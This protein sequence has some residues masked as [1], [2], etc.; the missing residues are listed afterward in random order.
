MAGGGHHLAQINIGRLRAPIDSPE[1]AEFV[2]NL[3]RINALAEAQPGFVWRLTGGGNNAT[4][5]AI[6]GDPLLIPNM[7]LWTSLEALAAF[8][9]RSGH[10]EIMRRRREWFERLELSTAIWWVPAGHTPSLAEGLERLELLRRL[11]PTTEA[12]SFR[13]PFPPPGSAEDAR[14]ILDEC[15]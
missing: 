15:A 2:A 13:T 6:G 8:V 1:V 3:D 4:D 12:F 10:V 11:G 14:P 9:Y 5:L 7:S